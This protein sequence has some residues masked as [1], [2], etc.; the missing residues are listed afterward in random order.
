MR[1]LNRLNLP[2]L[3]E[4]FIFEDTGR[5]IYAQEDSQHASSSDDINSIFNRP[6]EMST[7]SVLDRLLDRGAQLV[8]LGLTL[9]LRSQWVFRTERLLYLANQDT[10]SVFITSP[11]S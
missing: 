9:E 2:K 3:R 8:K 5:S 1:N 4:L 7:R 11:K 6:W 10:D